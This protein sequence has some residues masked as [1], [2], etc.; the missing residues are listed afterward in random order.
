MKQHFAR[1]WPWYAASVAS[2][3]CILAGQLVVAVLVFGF[4]AGMG[5]HDIVEGAN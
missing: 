2:S 3:V 4:F 5:L 1:E